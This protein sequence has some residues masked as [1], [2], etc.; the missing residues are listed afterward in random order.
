VPGRITGVTGDTP[1]IV[2]E[3][4]TVALSFSGDSDDAA[5]GP[6]FTFTGVAM[7]SEGL[8]CEEPGRW[9]VNGQNA[10]LQVS[11]GF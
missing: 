1:I 6:A 10:T 8:S 2:N 7:A 5:V 9:K 11:L 4:A 3:K